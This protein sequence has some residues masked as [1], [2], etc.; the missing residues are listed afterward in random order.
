M[1][2]GLPNFRARFDTRSIKQ[3]VLVFA[4]FAIVLW[5]HS[6]ITLMT[7]CWAHAINASNDFWSII[8]RLFVLVSEQNRR[9]SNWN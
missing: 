1:P 4:H 6:N 9:A 2:H 3:I 5:G 8:Y 7:V